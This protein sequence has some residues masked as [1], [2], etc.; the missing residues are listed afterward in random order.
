MRLLLLC[1]CSALLRAETILCLGDSLTAGLG[2]DESQA[3]PALV[4]GKAKA[5]GHDWT[6]VNAGVSGDTS[7]AAQQ[8]LAWALRS[9][10]DVVIIALG[11]NDGMRGVDPSITEANLR[12]IITE[13][14]AAGARPL[15]AGMQL[16]TNFGED[17][18]TAFATL[19]PR[20]ASECD[21]ALIPFLL[22]GVGGHPELNQSDD[23]HPNPAGHA[24]IATT[25]YHAVDALLAVTP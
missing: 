25:V 19:Y 17:H 16:P 13:V 3:W 18:R 24:I 4:A 7:A 1:L 11:G 8:R 12:A 15:L 21:I 6:L 5:A 20:L 10:P 22:E 2:V 9:K 23:I 14:Q